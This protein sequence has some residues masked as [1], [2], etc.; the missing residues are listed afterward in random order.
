VTGGHD[1]QG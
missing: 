1:L